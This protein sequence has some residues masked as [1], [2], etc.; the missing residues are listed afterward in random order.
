MKHL[1]TIIALTGACSV[2]AQSPTPDPKEKG[3]CIIE[4]KDYP[5]HPWREDARER[6]VTR[7]RCNEKHR[8]VVRDFGKEIARARFEPREPKTSKY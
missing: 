3:D 6:N 1:I 4:F 5:S 7:E 2:F 8:E